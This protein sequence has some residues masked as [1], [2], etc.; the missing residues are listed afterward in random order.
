MKCILLI[1]LGASVTT[2]AT[3][4]YTELFNYIVDKRSDY[5]L[6]I[7]KDLYRSLKKY[8]VLRSDKNVIILK[9]STSSKQKGGNTTVAN[10]TGSKQI[11]TNKGKVRIF[12]GKRLSFLRNLKRWFLFAIYFTKISKENNIKVV[13]GVFTGGIW[14]WP[15]AKFFGIKLIFS[16]NSH[17][18]ANT[19]KDKLNF[20]QSDYWVLKYCDI[21]D[22]LSPQMKITMERFI[23]KRNSQNYAVSPNSFIN[24]RNFY[25]E[26]PKKDNVIFMCRLEPHKNP[27][28]L[29]EAANIFYKKSD[30]NKIVKFLIMGTG[31]LDNKIRQYIK[32]NNLNGVKFLGPIPNLY[33]IVRKSKIFI[34]IQDGN[35]YPSQ[36]LIEA[37]ACENAIIASDVGETRL[38]VTENEG[39]LVD[40]DAAEIADAIE[41]LFTTPDLIERFG[42]NARKKVIENHTIEKFAEY[43]YSITSY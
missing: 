15:L 32:L 14:V 22:F 1:H 2:G 18:F 5:L 42:K 4:R 25:P 12:I 9:I 43:F 11:I 35:N 16:A 29:L 24:Y 26:Y 17:S 7:N 39:I 20:F 27:L 28:L 36:S 30:K 23:V 40:L 6:I 19:F 37:M 3:R 8:H 13:Y 38:L 31:S 21:I 34:S 10:K 41:K 33:H